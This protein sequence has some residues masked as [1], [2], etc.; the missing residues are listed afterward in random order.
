M[1]NVPDAAEARYTRNEVTRIRRDS[2]TV[3][4]AAAPS[5]YS[6]P[7]LARPTFHLSLPSSTGPKMTRLRRAGC[8][9]LALAAC[10]AVQG[11]RP[12]CLLPLAKGPQMDGMPTHGALDRRPSHTMPRPLQ[13]PWRRRRARP[14]PMRECPLPGRCRCCMCLFPWPTPSLQQ[15][16]CSLCS[17]LPARLP[18]PRSIHCL[19]AAAA[20]AC[21]STLETPPA[22]AAPAAKDREFR[23]GAEAR[24]FQ[25]HCGAGSAAG[26]D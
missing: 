10:A 14:L 12:A 19:A 2:S 26:V 24:P 20:A 22:V 3:L 1:E 21:C 18:P 23:E 4:P 25:V 17:S 6:K 7:R 5:R 13:A 9:L 8:L 11:E 16:P 15:P